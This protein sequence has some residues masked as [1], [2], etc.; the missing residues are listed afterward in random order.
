M[1]EDDLKRKL[2]KGRKKLHFTLIDPTKQSPK[3]ASILAKA[4]E[5][6]GSDAIMV[7]GTTVRTRGSVYRTVEAIRRVARLPVILF[8]NSAEAVSENAD[9]IFF[10]TLLNSKDF[11]YVVEEQLKGAPLVKK[12]GLKAISMGYILINTS[13]KPTAV[14][15][16]VNLDRLGKE[17]TEKIVDYALVVQYLG[18]DCLY[19]EAGSGAE[20]PISNEIISEVKKN[21][22][23]P[24]I[25]GGGIR[26]YQTAKEKLK[27]GAKVIV[28]GTIIETDV[29]KAKRII[30]AIKKFR[31]KS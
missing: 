29:K 23:I 22:R 3:E 11:T 5:K 4:A 14:E 25:V 20:E 9:Y 6:A 17:N 19:L 13:K 1:K 8:P 28:T 27:A 26:D 15:R 16:R 31:K 18:M 12:F 10:M 24:I 7:G 21:V 2:L 30:S